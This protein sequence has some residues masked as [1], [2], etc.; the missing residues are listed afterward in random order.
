ME[1]Y[2]YKKMVINKLCEINNNSHNFY[3]YKGL[4]FLSKLNENNKNL[5]IIF[6]SAIPKSQIGRN[7]VLFRGYDYNINNVDIICISD[8]L[9]DK[10]NDKYQ[11]NWTLSTTKYNCDNIYKELFTFLIDDKKYNKVI[12]TGTSA[13]GYPS[14]KFASYY[15]KY[16]LVS[17]PQIY[18]ENYSQNK[19]YYY[20]LNMLSQNNDKLNYNEKNIENHILSSKPAK[21][22]YYINEYDR[23]DWHNAYNDYLQFKKFIDKNNLEKIINFHSFKGNGGNIPPHRIHFPNNKKHIKILEEYFN[24]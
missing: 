3:N 16:A 24:L 2:G 14:I 4:N 6:H 12:F 8:Y 11:V 19:G 9:L 22:I 10:Y 20:L 18:L 5:L 15:K 17:N 7:K 13:G 23:A 21:I 1:A